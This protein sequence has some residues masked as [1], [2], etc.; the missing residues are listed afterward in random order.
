MAVRGR[1]FGRPSQMLYM[2]KYLA[3]GEPYIWPVT[4]IAYKPF[5]QLPVKYPVLNRKT[6]K[7][8]SACSLG[9]KRKDKKQQRWQE[10][11]VI[12]W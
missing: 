11:S 2:V 8:A 1:I 6:E 4:Q 3:L 12:S 7:T 5:D 10:D 9:A